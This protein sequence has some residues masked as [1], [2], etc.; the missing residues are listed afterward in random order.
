MSFNIFNIACCK[1]I[2]SKYFFVAIAYQVIN[3]V[4][5]DKTGSACDQDG[6]DF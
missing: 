2:E 4:A 3:D 6:F 5:S 1:I